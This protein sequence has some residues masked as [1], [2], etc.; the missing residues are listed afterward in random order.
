MVKKIPTK[1]DQSTVSEV[2]PV[3]ASYRLL[4][5][6]E[7]AGTACTVAE[8]AAA[9]GW[10]AGTVRSYLTKKWAR[11][12]ERKRG[13]FT[14]RGVGSFSEAEYLRLMSQNNELSADPRRPHLHV[15]VETLVRKA[16]ESALLALHIYN[17]PTTVFRTEG[18]S[19]LMV[20]AWTSLF[21]AIFAKRGTA[22]FYMEPDGVTPKMVDGDQKAWELAT[23]MRAYWNDAD[24]A[25]RRNLD[26]FIRLR[27]RIE[28]RYVPEIDPH[29]AAECQ[30]L[31]FNFDELLVGA[32]GA[33][34]AIRDSLAVPLQTANLRSAAQVEVLKALQ[35]RHFDEVT[36][37][38][39]AY[40]KDLPSGVYDDPKFAF[41]VYLVP[42]A[43]NHSNTSDLTME[44]VKHDP[45]RPEEM[46]ELQNKIALIKEKQVEVINANLLSP[47]DVAQQVSKRI[48]KPFNASS[49][50]ARAWAR[51][52][53]RKKGFDP[54]GCDRKYCVPDARHKDYSYTPEWV[55]FLVSK[56]MIDEEYRA[57]VGGQN[58]RI[59]PASSPEAAAPAKDTT[60]H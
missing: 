60:L 42:K 5:A 47:K 59:S 51:Y 7:R 34:Y 28:H 21:H 25:C 29:V 15:D 38:I 32:F 36:Q 17:S 13:S 53:V 43:G 37:F 14:V 49:H 50:H 35:S 23:C 55:E 12:V 6:H 31:L 57:V 2:E 11:F 20:I 52:G 56:M 10:K 26:F 24:H 9:T 18:F 19:V 33:Y 3:V 1:A 41:R 30:S 45:S 54:S 22:Y 44:F 48:G 39:H 27:N 8:V 16:R 58:V 46:A 40:R 4:V